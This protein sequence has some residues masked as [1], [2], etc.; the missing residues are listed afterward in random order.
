MA[1]SFQKPT[2]K[3]TQTINENE[4]EQESEIIN[5]LDINTE[6][7]TLEDIESNKKHLKWKSSRTGR[8]TS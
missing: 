6:Q 8:N 4:N 2:R 1:Q 7:F 3:N 5:R